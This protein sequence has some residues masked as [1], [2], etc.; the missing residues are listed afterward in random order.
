MIC[1]YDSS[2]ESQRIMKTQSI[3]PG[4]NRRRDE[5]KHLLEERRR[6]LLQEVQGKIRDA[7]YSGAK[8]RGVQDE[9]EACEVDVQ[10]EIGFALLQITGETL[11]AVDVALARLQEG[12]YGR[13]LECG[14]EIHEGRLRALPFAV[15]C[16]NCE[17]AR[18]RTTHGERALRSRRGPQV[19]FVE[20]YR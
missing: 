3:T 19:L 8:E 14:D 11:N 10:A 7:R 12:T 15:R 17:E 20:L 4:K 16:R 18:E 2:K 13:C 9:G 6:E 5:L 1:L